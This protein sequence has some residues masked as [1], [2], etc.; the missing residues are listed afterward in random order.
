M[1]FSREGESRGVRGTRRDSQSSRSINA[2]NVDHNA[3]LACTNMVNVSRSFGQRGL[4]RRV[5]EGV[6]QGCKTP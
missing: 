5:P 6:A 1:C 3:G 4:R 2:T